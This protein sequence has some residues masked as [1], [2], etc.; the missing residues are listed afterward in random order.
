VQYLALSLLALC[1]IFQHDVTEAACLDNQ[2]MSGLRRP[3]C[4][5]W[6]SSPAFW[7]FPAF[8]GSFLC[9]I[10]CITYSGPNKSCLKCRSWCVCLAK[11]ESLYQKEDGWPEMDL[12]VNNACCTNTMTLGLDLLTCLS[13]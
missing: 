3:E 13:P 8:E 9:G 11:R 2:G 7:S 10:P 5:Y 4:L 6:F 1:N 12:L